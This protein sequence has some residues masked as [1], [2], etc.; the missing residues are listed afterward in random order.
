MLFRSAIEHSVLILIVI[1]WPEQI[2]SPFGQMPLRLGPTD[3]RLVAG[4]VRCSWWR[5]IDTADIDMLSARVT[6]TRFEMEAIAR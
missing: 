5:N 1:R 4:H 3:F 2:P 6:P